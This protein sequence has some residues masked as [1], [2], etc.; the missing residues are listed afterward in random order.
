MKHSKCSN[1][2]LRNVS[3]KTLQEMGWLPYE[4]PVEERFKDQTGRVV[5]AYLEEHDET[6]FTDNCNDVKPF[7]FEYS[8]SFFEVSSRCVN[9]MINFMNPTKNFL[10]KKPIRNDNIIMYRHVNP[11]YSNIGLRVLVENALDKP[12]DG[13]PNAY[14]IPQDLVNFANK[15]CAY[16]TG[17]HVFLPSKEEYRKLRKKYLHFSFN[18]QISDIANNLLVNG[19][20][21][22]KVDKTMVA[23]RIVYKGEILANTKEKKHFFD[24][25]DSVEL[26]ENIEVFKNEKDFFIEC[27]KS[28]MA[29]V[30]DKYGVLIDDRELPRKYD[31]SNDHLFI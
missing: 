16:N 4:E 5:P 26:H 7:N 19:P 24:Y 27:N 13:I 25:E 14:A 31:K 17:R 29:Y 21:F 23:S 20:E 15:V 22:T 18:E 12:F 6:I 10:E 28:S 9:K 30:R 3:V 11:G 1:D 8:N 2:C